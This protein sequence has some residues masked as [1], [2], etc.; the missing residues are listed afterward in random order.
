MV[1]G[2][3][4]SSL[5]CWVSSAFLDVVLP[6]PSLATSDVP[7]YRE[8]SRIMVANGA[9]R[10]WPPLAFS[11]DAGSIRRSLP[12]FDEVLPLLWISLITMDPGHLLTQLAQCFSVR[13]SPGSCF[14]RFGPL[15]GHGREQHFSSLFFVFRSKTI[16]AQFICWVV[17]TFFIVLPVVQPLSTFVAVGGCWSR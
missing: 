7:A 11:C 10:R 2:A 14:S 6:W 17:G 9:A 1:R 13:C 3:R 15:G 12:R 8:T 16:A 5:C 4:F